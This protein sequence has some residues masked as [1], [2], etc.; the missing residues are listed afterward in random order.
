MLFG[1]VDILV[2]KGVID[3]DV[4]R[5]HPAGRVRPK[6]GSFVVALVRKSNGSPVERI[7]NRTLSMVIGCCGV[8]LRSRR[9]VPSSP[10][11]P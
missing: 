3:L 1:V 9:R 5:G 2:M 8:L 4:E 7:N 6:S 10:S 11:P